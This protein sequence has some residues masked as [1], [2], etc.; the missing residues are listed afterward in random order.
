MK[1]TIEI[2]RSKMGSAI[3][4]V[5]DFRGDDTVVLKKEYLREACHLLK[6]ELGFNMLMD[7]CAVDYPERKE[8]FDVVYH[9][10]ALEKRYRLRVKVRVGEDNPV[11]ESVHDIWKAANWF[12]R[13]AFDMF[14][15]KFDGHSN[16]KRLLTFEG[17]EGHPL[18]KDYPRNKRQA[19][20]V[21]DPLVDK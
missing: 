12:E 3:V 4:E 11:I 17:F 7:I 10:Y 19:I 9:L 21:P 1:Q 14:G 20:P 8:R 18:R 2:I 5:S 16:L 13:E 6:D 15:I